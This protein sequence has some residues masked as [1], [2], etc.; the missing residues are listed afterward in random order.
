MRF[1][2]CASGGSVAGGRAARGH[3][4]HRPQRG[5]RCARPGARRQLR[6]PR[7]VRRGVRQADRHRCA[8]QL[9]AA[10]CATSWAWSPD[11]LDTDRDAARRREVPR[12]P[13]DG[14]RRGEGQPGA[15][16]QRAR[17]PAQGRAE[18][19][20]VGRGGRSAHGAAASVAALCAAGRRAGG[21]RRDDDLA[22]GA[23]PRRDAGPAVRRPVQADR[24]RRAGPHRGGSLSPDTG[25][26]TRSSWIASSISRNPTRP[27]GWSTCRR[28]SSTWWSGWGRPTSRR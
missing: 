3:A 1:A 24:A 11:N 14:C 7:R 15:L 27:C 23:W 28:D 22:Q 9:R 17:K 26:R 10:A 19:G 13:G 20:V 5:P 25:T 16:P 18:A 12:R 21:S 4:A 6:R 8:E 2:V